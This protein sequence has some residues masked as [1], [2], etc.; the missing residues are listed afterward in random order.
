MFSITSWGFPSSFVLIVVH[1]NGRV[2][3]CPFTCLSM[4]MVL[5]LRTLPSSVNHPRLQKLPPYVGREPLGCFSLGP[6]FV[7]L[8]W[9][10]KK[11]R[12]RPVNWLGLTLDVSIS[13]LSG[14]TFRVSFPP[15]LLFY[16]GVSERHYSFQVPLVWTRRIGLVVLPFGPS[17]VSTVFVPVHQRSHSVWSLVP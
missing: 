8:E 5:S 11:K 3:T 17:M 7:E 13:G 10:R 14:P 15:H 4:T 9:E 6:L 2:R 16:R 1:D 12:C